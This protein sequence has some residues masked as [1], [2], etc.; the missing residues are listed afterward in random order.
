[1]KTVTIFLTIGIFICRAPVVGPTLGQT[2]SMPTTSKTDPWNGNGFGIAEKQDKP[3]VFYHIFVRSFR[4]SDG[5][6]EGDLRGITESLDYLE[7]LGVTSL[8]L[9]P[10]YP[11]RF[12]HNYF[13]DNFEGIDVEFGDMDDFAELVK[14]IHARQMKIFIDQ[15][16]HYVTGRHKWLIRSR[17]NPSSPFADYVLFQDEQNRI[18]LPGF[19]GIIDLPVWTGET[20][21]HYTV[22]L[23]SDQ[24][25][26][27]F[28]DFFAKWIDP[29]GDGEFTDGVDGFRIDHMMDDLDGKKL[30]TNLFEDFWAPLFAKLRTQ[31]PEVEF[32]AEQADWTSFGSAY[33]KRANVDRVFS[34]NLRNA[35]VKMN[36]KRIASAL[37]RM[38]QVTPTG[39]DQLVFI[40]NHDTDRFAIDERDRPDML[41]AAAALNLLIGWTPIIYYGQELGM[42]G[43][44]G[45]PENYGND[46]NDI[47]VREAF[48]WTKAIEGEGTATWYRRDAPYWNNPFN[49]AG[50]GVSVEEQ[51]DD[52]QSLLNYYKS[53]IALR[54]RHESFVSGSSE[55]LPTPDGLLAVS[56]RTSDELGVLMVNLTNQQI[57]VK[58]PLEIA[59]ASNRFGESSVELINGTIT[60]K[61]PS[62]GVSVWTFAR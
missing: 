46:A 27:Y 51:A 8:L 21:D 29:N 54:S 35:I 25:K 2:V 9:T 24:V 3:E 50:D 49:Q 22:N 16:I 53:L 57:V 39:R 10:L 13:A 33:F 42:S 31:N 59:E 45:R 6:D 40:E 20:I 34:F 1:M 38:R 55:L 30:L 28:A 61:L 17:N 47:G 18:P 19:F 43:A 5:D 44:Q 23:R 15:E 52:P 41:R 37:K 62:Y 36:K 7:D 60:G 12:Y 48:R 58:V 14:E 32:I 26:R 4:D 56:R 11:S